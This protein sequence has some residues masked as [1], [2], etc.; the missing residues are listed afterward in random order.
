VHILYSPSTSFNNNKT[1][2]TI[3]S[4]HAC[5]TLVVQHGGCLTRQARWQRVQFGYHGAEVL[6]GPYPCFN[7]YGPKIGSS[8]IRGQN[9]LA[10]QKQPQGAPA[11]QDGIGAKGEFDIF[12]VYFAGMG[13]R[14]GRAHEQVLPRN[15]EACHLA[16]TASGLSGNCSPLLCKMIITCCAAK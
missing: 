10:S 12:V 4:T 13:G 11:N 3:H 5:T 15:H 8:W 6:G 2:H 7:K 1:L 16:Q 9:S 14:K